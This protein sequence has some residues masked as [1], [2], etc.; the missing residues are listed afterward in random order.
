MKIVVT[1]S[2]GNISKPLTKI[3]TAKGHN[4]VVISSNA[5]RQKDIEA[6]GAVAAIGSVKDGDFL[7]NTFNSA[8]A[9]YTMIPPNFAAPDPIAYYEHIGNSYTKAIDLSGV[10]RV[11]NLSS[12]GADLPSGT[13]FIVGS[14]RVEQILNGLHGAV[15]THL[16]PCSF[17]NN[18]LHYNGMIKHAG[19]IGSNYGGDDL[20]TLVS[21]ED[22]AA[23]AASE[24]ETSTATEKIRYIASDEHTCNEIARIL[25]AAIGK[26]DLKW[27]TLTDEQVQEGMERNGTP[28]HIAAKLVELNA[29]I[30]SGALR[31]DYDRHKPA[32][33][34]KVKL[35]DF[36][37]TFAAAF[38]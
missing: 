7:T 13:G 11:V 4:V 26:P 27:V 28:P 31:A 37:R 23:V 22:I 12:W 30:H 8:D 18:L 6:L 38:N 9:V 19:F 2:L 24:L 17:Y 21:T 29:S 15:I 14:Y 16:R 5:E 36:A 33:M 1:G 25:G 20:V 32:E 10:K 35:E 34:G 3:L